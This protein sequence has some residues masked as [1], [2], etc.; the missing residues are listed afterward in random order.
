MTANPT[1]RPLTVALVGLILLA[2]GFTAA[3]GLR[4]A[5]TRGVGMAVDSCAA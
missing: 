4:E 1:P 5:K 3:P 2:V